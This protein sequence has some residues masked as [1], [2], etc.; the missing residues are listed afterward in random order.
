MRR[1]APLLLFAAFLACKPAQVAPGPGEAVDCVCAT[2]RD[3]ACVL[4]TKGPDT[5][6]TVYEGR[7][8]YFCSDHCKARFLKDPEKYKNACP[9]D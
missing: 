8:Y 9:K 5:P 4:V 6:Q 3:L 7:T 2:D 1:L